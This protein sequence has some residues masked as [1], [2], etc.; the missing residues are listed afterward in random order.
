M[1]NI[2]IE[3]REIVCKLGRTDSEGYKDQYGLFITQ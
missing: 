1:F 3:I 2:K